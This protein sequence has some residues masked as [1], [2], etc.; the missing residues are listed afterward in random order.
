MGSYSHYTNLNTLST[1]AQGANN[2]LDILKRR[3]N[4]NDG[5]FFLSPTAILT[6]TA[7]MLQRLQSSLPISSLMKRVVNF[8]CN[9]KLAHILVKLPGWLIHYTLCYRCEL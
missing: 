4:Q 6:F 1:Q 9:P 8:M 2:C 3:E 5:R 7:A